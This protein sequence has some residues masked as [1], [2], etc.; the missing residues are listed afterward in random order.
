MLGRFRSCKVKMLSL[1]LLLLQLL[2]SLLTA[3]NPSGVAVVGGAGVNGEAT[4]DIDIFGAGEGDGNEGKRLTIPRAF[5]AVV[6]VPR[7][8]IKC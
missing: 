2:F 8:W 4:D 1:R 6:Q 5:F 7:K 3:G